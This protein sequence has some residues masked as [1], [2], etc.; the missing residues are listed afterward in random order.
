MKRIVDEQLHRARKI[1]NEDRD[2]VETV[3]AALLERESIDGDEFKLL[4]EGKALPEM[5]LDVDRST[6][7]E[8]AA[9][10]ASE[11]TTPKA[12]APDTVEESGSVEE[13]ASDEESTPAPEDE[14]RP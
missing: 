4:M 13:P 11:P 8:P 3:M 12:A 6:D 7:D 9:T 2:S 14:P 1:L 5:E 10:P